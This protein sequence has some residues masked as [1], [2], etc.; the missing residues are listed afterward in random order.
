MRFTR[1]SIAAIALL[2]LCV[3]YH[4][5]AL[6]SSGALWRDEVSA[7]NLAQLPDLPAMYHSLPYDSLPLGY[8]LLVRGWIAIFGGT[9]YSLR[10]FGMLGGLALLAA[11]LAAARALGARKPLVFLAIFAIHPAVIY[12][13]D[14]VR[15]YGIGTAA[16]L[17]AMIAIWRLLQRPGIATWIF[18]ALATTVSVQLLYHN[19][20]F[21][22]GM[23]AA[24]AIVAIRRRNWRAALLVLASGAVAAASLAIYIPV[25]KSF[26]DSVTRIAALPITIGVIFDYLR[27]ALAAQGVWVYWFWIALAVIAMGLLVLRRSG[28]VAFITI[29]TIL[30]GAFFA[31]LLLRVKLEPKIAYY[32][33]L[34]AMI[35]LFIDSALNFKRPALQKIALVILLLFVLATI[36]ANWR[37]LRVRHTSM[38]IACRVLNESAA[39]GDLIV[40]QPWHF[41]VGFSRYYTG[42]ATWTTAPPISD[43]L[44]YRYDE[45]LQQ[46]QLPDPI[47]PVLAKIDATLAAGHAVWVLGEVMFLPPDQLPPKLHPAPDPVWGWRHA[48][49]VDSYNLQVTH[50]LQQHAGQIQSI[51]LD[52]KPPIDDVEQVQLLNSSGNRH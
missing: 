8:V 51:V 13:G 17:V 32:I 50:F 49:Y 28:T 22:A 30:S 45:L 3:F 46:M 23:C 37:A 27:L 34:L 24:G 35:A 12:W 6:R 38:D 40:I 25:F 15:A 29:A 20:A 41:A 31:V 52:T 19:T 44:H 1:E 5:L 26:G 10:V 7:V 11:G 14:S 18:A 36:P 48:A 16:L 39:P 2:G 43:R 33:P 4:L 21:I 9:D 47:A 42:P